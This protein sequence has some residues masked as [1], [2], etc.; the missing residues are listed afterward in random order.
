MSNIQRN[1]LFF[2][3]FYSGVIF[4]RP[5]VAFDGFV[6]TGQKAIVGLA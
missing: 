2:D 6:K 3:G 4:A 5:T 1:R